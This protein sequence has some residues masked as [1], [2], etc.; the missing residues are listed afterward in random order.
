MKPQLDDVAKM[1]DEE[2][3]KALYRLVRPRY[4]FRPTYYLPDAHWLIQAMARRKFICSLDYFGEGRG[5]GWEA[6]FILSASVGGY[7]LKC[8]RSHFGD[9]CDNRKL[10]FPRAVSEAALRALRARKAAEPS[11]SGR[12]PSATARRKAK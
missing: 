10:D 4:L 7:P 9:E 12:K 5:G 8:F 6:T 3:D 11:K 1:T 2:L